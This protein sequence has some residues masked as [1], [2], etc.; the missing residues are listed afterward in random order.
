MHRGYLLQC[1]RGLE[2]ASTERAI[3][4]RAYPF[5]HSNQRFDH[6][7]HF[8]TCFCWFIHWQCFWAWWRLHLQSSPDWYR[9]VSPCG[10]LYQHV[11]DLVLLSS[12][13]LP[14]PDI[15]QTKHHFCAL[16]DDLQRDWRAFRNVFHGQSNEKVQEAITCINH[17]FNFVVHCDWLQCLH[18]HQDVREAIS[19]RTQ[20]LRRRGYML[21]K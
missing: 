7:V 18:K 21:K 14:V 4:L 19:G 5:M 2:R 20:Y 11:H 3:Q 10:C 8:V 9:C 13:L 6:L 12:L 15:W 17:S 1:E 16:D